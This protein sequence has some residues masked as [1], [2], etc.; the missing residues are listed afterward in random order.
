MINTVSVAKLRVGDVGYTQNC[1]GYKFYEVVGFTPTTVKIRL[2]RAKAPYTYK[3][4]NTG[5]PCIVGSKERIYFPTEA[6]LV[7]VRETVHQNNLKIGL[8][9]KCANF[10]FHDLSLPL[11]QEVSQLLEKPHEK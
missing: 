2:Q 7:E 1:L 3:V 11:L 6:A 10:N 9:R 5:E 4:R 8:A